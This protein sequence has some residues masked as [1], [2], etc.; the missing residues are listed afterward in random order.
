MGM[1]N[2]AFTEIGVAETQNV[3][4]LPDKINEVYQKGDIDGY[5]RGITEGGDNELI[6]NE[7]YT[8]GKAEV[9]AQNSEILANCNTQLESKGVGTAES[10]EQVPE[11]IA[12]IKGEI[13]DFSKMKYVRFYDLNGFTSSDVTLQLGNTQQTVQDFQ[14]ASFIANNTVEHLTLNVNDSIE[15][16]T[17]AC[18]CNSVRDNMLKHLTLNMPNA[19]FSSGYGIFTYVQALEII[20]GTPIDLSLSPDTANC[21]FIGCTALREIR[22]APNT[23][24]G[25]MW[26][27]KS[28]NLSDE[29]IQSIVD[30][31]ADL[32]GQPAKTVTF[33]KDLV[34][35]VQ[36]DQKMAIDAKNWTQVY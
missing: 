19:K 11:K 18:Q 3:L 1:C 29:T 21:E 12:E 28:P 20:D 4:S 15:K 8:A 30:G 33:P 10:L 25:N 6:Y 16:I 2:A 35:I 9:E 17:F 14:Y 5:V 24:R 31:L 34:D 27:G 32:T 23:I 22:F 7:G 26:F 36:P 13:C